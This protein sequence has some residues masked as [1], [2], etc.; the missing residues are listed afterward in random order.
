MTRESQK[1]TRSQWMHAPVAPLWLWLCINEYSCF[2]SSCLLHARH[3]CRTAL[4]QTKTLKL[5]VT[6]SSHLPPAARVP[7]YAGLAVRDVRDL[8]CMHLDWARRL[9]SIRN[10]VGFG[11]FGARGWDRLALLANKHNVT[12][13]ISAFIKGTVIPATDT[14]TH[15]AQKR[16]IASGKSPN[17]IASSQYA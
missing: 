14:L 13:M 10:G 1:R 6:A 17:S 15:V 16:H 9:L 4:V 5:C 2:F 11:G 8:E 12:V 3:A 7:I